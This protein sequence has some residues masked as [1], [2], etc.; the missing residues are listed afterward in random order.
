MDSF[1]KLSGSATFTPTSRTF[2][3]KYKPNLKFL[4]GT[5]AE[6][7]R[8]VDEDA[9]RGQRLELQLKDSPVSGLHGRERHPGRMLSAEERIADA[10]G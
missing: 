5:D 1:L 4:T 2:E 7:L 9:V 8:H 6:T 3:F 10:N